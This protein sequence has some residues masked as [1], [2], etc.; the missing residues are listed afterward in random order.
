MAEA[1]NFLATQRI[2]VVTGA[3]KGI[4]LEICRQLASKGI[5]VILTARD[6]KKGAEAIDI[7]KECGLSNYVIFHKLDVTDP[8]TIAQLKDFIKARFGKLD[9]LQDLFIEKLKVATQTYDVAEECLKTNY[10][11][12]KQMIQELLPLLQFSDS[13]RIVNVSSLAG[14]L[15]HVRNEWAVGVLSDAENLT[16]DRVD[17]VL[18]AFLQDLKDG[19]M[20]TEKWSL[21]FPAYTLSKAAMNAYT[22]ILAKKY[23]SFLI[24]CVCPGYV[25]TDMTINGGKLSVEEGA[26]SPVWLALLPEGGPSGIYFNRKE[27]TPF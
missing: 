11:G 5:V 1:S 16:E 20:E 27:V 7:L 25:K 3:N 19:L 23:P 2:A 24:N 9:I 10:Y 15:E 21:I 12:A 17:E 18:N 8:S 13:P 22:R 6:E 14:K 26:E 4:G